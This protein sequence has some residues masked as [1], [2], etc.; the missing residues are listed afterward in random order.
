MPYAE[1]FASFDISVD[2]AVVSVVLNLASPGG[3]GFWVHS[4]MVE[5]PLYWS[6]GG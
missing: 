1:S 6:D 4:L 5:D 3:G 2:G